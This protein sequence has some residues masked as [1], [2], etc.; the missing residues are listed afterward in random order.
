M[1]RT[2]G[3]LTTTFKPDK[4]INHIVS[5]IEANLSKCSVFV[6]DISIEIAGASDKSISINRELRYKEIYYTL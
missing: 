3:W 2:D 4:Q 6:L 5:Y 1:S